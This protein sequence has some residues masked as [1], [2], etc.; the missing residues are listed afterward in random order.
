MQVL[1]SPSTS[2]KINYSTSI[3]ARPKEVRGKPCPSL[4]LIKSF[5]DLIANAF[6]EGPHYQ[7]NNK[8]IVY[9]DRVALTGSNQTS[10]KTSKG[11]SNPLTAMY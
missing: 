1:I 5:S 6:Q 9:S 10:Q 7:L 2:Y 11:Y 8:S 4:P 3:P